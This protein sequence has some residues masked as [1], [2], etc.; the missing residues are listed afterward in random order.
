MQLAFRQEQIPDKAMWDESKQRKAEA[1]KFRQE[2]SK[3][4][5]QKAVMKMQRQLAAQAEVAARRRS[6]KEAG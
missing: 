3:E 5:A 4:R 1:A 2:R 6:A